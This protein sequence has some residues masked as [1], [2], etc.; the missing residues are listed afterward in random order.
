MTQLTIPLTPE[1]EADLRQFGTVDGW[2]A[3]A[4]L[5]SALAEAWERHKAE[6]GQEAHW[7][8]HWARMDTDPEYRI[9]WTCRRCGQPYGEFITDDNGMIVHMDRC[10]TDAAHRQNDTLVDNRD[11]GGH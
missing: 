1:L 8:D 11:T 4:R 5:L 9:Q 6:Q 2:A 10:P 7:I 3:V